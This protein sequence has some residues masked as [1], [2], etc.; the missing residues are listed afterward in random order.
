[1]PTIMNPISYPTLYGENIIAAESE[2]FPSRY[3]IVAT[4]TPWSIVEPLLHHSPAEVT[5]VSD[6]EISTLDAA[7]E[8]VGPVEAFV[9]V[10]AGM[11]IDAAKYVAWRRGVNL[12]QIPTTTSSNAM[13]TPSAG[14]R[15]APVRPIA[16]IIPEAILVD[17]QVIQQAPPLG[18]LFSYPK[19][20]TGPLP[21]LLLRTSTG[22]L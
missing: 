21:T 19:T 10:G 8:Q 15:S 3:A 6:L 12:F 16:H 9:G 4:P 22:T 20:E 18:G 13:F 7:L 14:V 1:M 2:R 17:F 5:L 11:A